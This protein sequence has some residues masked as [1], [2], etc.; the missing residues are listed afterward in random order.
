MS[1][2]AGIKI[3]NDS[4]GKP[5]YARIDL[6]KYGSQ[7]NPFLSSIGAIDDNDIEEEDYHTI[8]AV[9]K[10]LVEMTKKHFAKK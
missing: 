1:R 2:V 3:E 7:I 5:R 4:K 10:H 6:K 9:E 8:E